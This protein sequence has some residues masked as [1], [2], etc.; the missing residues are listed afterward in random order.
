MARTTIGKLSVQLT[1][2]TAGFQRAMGRAGKTMAAIGKQAARVGAAVAAVGAAG[3]AAAAGGL[4]A[5]TRKGL[6]SGDALGKNADRLGITT[7]ALAGLQHGAELAGVSQ[8]QLTKSLQRYNRSVG[9][10]LE[11]TGPAAEALADLGISAQKLDR[12]S[13][14]EGVA[15]IADELNKLESTAE[16][17][18]IAF[19]LFGRSGIELFTLFQGGSEGLAAARAEAERL[20]L[21]ISRVEASKIEAANDAM[22]RARRVLTGV[23]QQLAVK[24]SPIIRNLATA[25]ERLATRSGSVGDTVGDAVNAVLGWIA[26]FGDGI[27]LVRESMRGITALWLDWKATALESIAAVTDRITGVANVLAAQNPGLQGMLDALGGG[28]AAALHTAGSLARVAANEAAANVTITGT[29][30]YGNRIRQ[31]GRDLAAPGSAAG[32]DEAAEAVENG[33]QQVTD[34]LDELKNELQQLGSST[35]N[36]QLLRV[37]DRLVL[38]TANAR[39]SPAGGAGTADLGRAVA[40]L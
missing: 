31:L 38:A 13:A 25:W 22:T 26:N 36:A 32:R 19:D 39:L 14:D 6:E 4:A 15:L 30:S 21:T 5:L 9:E 18:R 20:G 8:D 10:A 2:N 34:K 17:S 35:V 23:G 16:K 3:L 12:M 28:A 11:G 29:D 40:A 33:A 7:E 27:D 1:A 37:M 24:L